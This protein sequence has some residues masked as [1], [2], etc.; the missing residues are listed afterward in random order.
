M[1]RHVGMF[2]V[3]IAKKAA[4]PLLTFLSSATGSIIVMLSRSEA[5]L[6]IE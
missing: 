5:S 4:K 1:A 6:V 2:V 3:N